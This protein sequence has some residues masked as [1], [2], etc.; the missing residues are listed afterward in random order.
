MEKEISGTI[1]VLKYSARVKGGPRSQYWVQRSGE[2]DK[3]PSLKSVHSRGGTEW[4]EA[5]SRKSRE[6]TAV[7]VNN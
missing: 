2:R 7:V 1:L 4:E 5:W 3:W 6:I